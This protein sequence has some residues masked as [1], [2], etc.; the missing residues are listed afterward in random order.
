MG[1]AVPF[2]TLTILKK[3]TV[4]S[5][6]AR[7]ALSEMVSWVGTI[8]PAAITT[9]QED[10]SRL[11]FQ[12]GN[13][14]FMRNWPYAYALGNASGSKVANKFDIVNMPYGGSNT[15][16]HACTGGW[17]LAINAY[18]PNVDASW[19]FI[20]YL[21]GSQAQKKLAIDASLTGALQNIYDDSEVLQ[22][23]P[24]FQK[25]KPVLQNAKPRPVSPS[26]PDL[27]TVLQTHLFAALKKQVSPADALSGLASDLQHRVS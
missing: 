20:H 9:Y 6:E 3:V 26:Y 12:N 14:A 24:L 21:L 1:T 4:N 17:N 5:P 22:K 7:Q 15:T 10:D 19:E 18:T 25:L 27:S 11:V 16:G 23:Q 13:S 8:S 2:L